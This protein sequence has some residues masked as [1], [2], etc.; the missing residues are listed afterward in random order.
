MC[1]S[2]FS[3]RVRGTCASAIVTIQIPLNPDVKHILVGKH[4]IDWIKVCVSVCVCDR[5]G[6]PDRHKSESSAKYKNWNFTREKRVKF[7]AKLTTEEYEK[8]KKQKNID[9]TRHHS[10]HLP[11]VVCY[12]FDA[13]ISARNLYPHSFFFINNVHQCNQISSV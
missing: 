5:L 7:G 2:T 9:A 6:L 3:E 8:N 10:P 11:I 4:T 13:N 1:W 12:A